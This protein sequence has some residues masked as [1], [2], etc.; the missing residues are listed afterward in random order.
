MKMATNNLVDLLANLRDVLAR[1]GD[2]VV[3]SVDAAL[4]SIGQIRDPACIAELLILL[5][6]H[7]QYD[8]AMF[9][10]IHAAESFDD[11]VYIPQLIAVLPALQT[12]AVKWASIALMRAINNQS[13]RDTL[14]GHLRQATSE[15]K[16]T[17]A[18]L[19]EE[20]NKRG[21]KFISKTLPVLLATK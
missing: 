6:D 11:S 14:V 2:G 18:W 21:T 4:V 12:K 9:S 10:L 8:E 7:A 20:I 15:S 19:C 3:T 17:V 16:Q 13:A 1:G 5:D